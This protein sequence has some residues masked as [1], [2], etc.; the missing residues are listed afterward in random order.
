MKVTKDFITI[1]DKL[2]DLVKLRNIVLENGNVLV[3]KP[4]VEE[5]TEGGIYISNETKEK[6]QYTTGFG[7]I[8]AIPRNLR[9]S[10]KDG[11]PMDADIRVGDY[12]IYSHA[13]HYRPTLTGLRVVLGVSDFP[14]HFL[15]VVSDPE[16]LMTVKK[17]IL[18]GN[19]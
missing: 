1:T 15:Y 6:E 4:Q 12:V 18:H 11:E 10:N 9:P 5:K 19:V 17:D 14:D 2:I 16:I 3:A 13:T 7:R 8:I